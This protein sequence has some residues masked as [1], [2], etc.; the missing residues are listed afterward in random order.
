MN[1][2]ILKIVYLVYGI[3]ALQDFGKKMLKDDPEIGKLDD[4]E[5]IQ[6]MEEK[7]IS[8]KQ[9]LDKEKRKGQDSLSPFKI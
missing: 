7:I 9:N 2:V 1:S 8:C 4:F 5:T 3:S 6:Q